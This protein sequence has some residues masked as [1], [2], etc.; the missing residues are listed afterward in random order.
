MSPDALEGLKTLIGERNLPKTSKEL[1]F[2]AAIINDAV[3]R[4]GADWVKR[5]REALLRQWDYCASLL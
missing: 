4:N 5:N 1:D 2:F 3:K